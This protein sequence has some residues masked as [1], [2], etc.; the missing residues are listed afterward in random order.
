[1]VFRQ[2]EHVKGSD[3]YIGL[4][5]LDEDHFIRLI[6]RKDYDY[7]VLCNFEGRVSGI[8]G[9]K[10]NR[11]IP[12]EVGCNPRWRKGP[13]LAVCWKIVNSCFSR[14]TKNGAAMLEIREESEETF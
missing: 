4:E 10:E 12:Q 2:P 7:R 5:F 11:H 13:D 9:C 3:T 6:S 8:S 14:S 1:M